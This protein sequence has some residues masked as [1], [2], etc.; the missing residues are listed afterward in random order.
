[1][2]LI[3]YI[4]NHKFGRELMKKANQ[5][6]VTPLDVAQRLNNP[7][8]MNLLIEASKLQNVNNKNLKKYQ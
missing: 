5:Q 8:L 7:G 4:L 2:E 6:G 1:M 3:K